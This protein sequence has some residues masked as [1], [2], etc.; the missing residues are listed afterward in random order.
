MV[1]IIA[2]PWVRSLF[3]AILVLSLPRLWTLRQRGRTR[4]LIGLKSAA[5]L[6]RATG[7]VFL[8]VG[9][10]I[11]IASKGESA[12][13]A[14]EAGLMG[15]LSAP[16]FTLAVVVARLMIGPPAMIVEER[17]LKRYW[18]GT[19]AMGAFLIVASAMLFIGWINLFDR[20]P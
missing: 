3:V 7:V 4:S 9:A 11:V 19:T 10:F 14:L 2:A 12:R 5:W 20:S 6:I 18:E 16:A 8:A 15:A 1:E 13:L 17:I